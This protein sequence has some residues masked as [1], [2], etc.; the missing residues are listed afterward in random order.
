MK[1]ISILAALGII[2]GLAKGVFPHY[3]SIGAY[4][5][6]SFGVGYMLG[7]EFG[8]KRG[9]KIEKDYQEGKV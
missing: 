5:L 8:I 7:K 6:L 3:L 9:R 2:I 4:G 1:T